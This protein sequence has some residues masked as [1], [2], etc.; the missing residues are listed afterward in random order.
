MAHTP[1]EAEGMAERAAE[2]IALGLAECV[3]EGL[4]LGATEGLVDMFKEGVGVP[5]GSSLG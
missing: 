3:T 1:G 2:G 5:E 4:A